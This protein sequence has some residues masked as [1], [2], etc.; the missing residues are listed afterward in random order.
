[1]HKNQISLINKNLVYRS[2]LF[3]LIVILAGCGTK[4]PE[5]PRVELFS[6]P[7]EISLTEDNYS[8][9]FYTFNNVTWSALEA[10]VV[11]YRLVSNQK[12]VNSVSS[13]P[14]G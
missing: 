3:L 12:K 8:N 5:I 4:S 7:A 13:F 9:D 2:F 6:L 14:Q 11:A 10:N 1:M